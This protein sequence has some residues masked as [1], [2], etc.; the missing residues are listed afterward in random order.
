M[1]YLVDTHCHLIFEDFKEDL[2]DVI[3]NAYNSGVKGMVVISTQEKEFNPIISLTNKYENLF[4]SIG[5]HP[6]SVK[7]HKNFSE[8]TLLKFTENIN[9]IGVGETGLDYYYENSE[10]DIQK[11]LFRKHINV[12]R[13]TQLPI[14]IHTRDADLDTI[15]ILK[16]EQKKGAFPGVIHCFTAGPELAKSAIELGL[17][18]SLSG[19]VTFKN[20]NSLRET[21]KNI[22][23]DKILVE[24]DSPY[25]SPEP[26]RGKRNEPANVV[27]TAKF[28][29]D[30]YDM[31]TDD[32]FKR[33]TNNFLS[34][35]KKAKLENA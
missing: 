25:L 3:N 17:F 12:S 6:H 19:I 15:S 26:L 16:E 5:I 13:E 35:F 33:T 30:F 4:C 8:D 32:F 18:I 31:N 1:T 28:L 24:T 29:A 2:H 34:L 22:P 7:D 27:H 10:K 14:I 23:I 9:V 20:A 11:A 21:I